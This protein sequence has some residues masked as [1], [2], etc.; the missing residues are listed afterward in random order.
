MAARLILEDADQRP[1]R[2]KI[3]CSF[4]DRGRRRGL[5]RAL[6]RPLGAGAAL[7]VVV[8]IELIAGLLAGAVTIIRRAPPRVEIA[9]SME[10]AQLP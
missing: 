6:A 3:G 1:D 5:A 4:L 7:V 2:K 9:A 8:V 10:L